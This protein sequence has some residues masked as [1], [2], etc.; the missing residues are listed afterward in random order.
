[1][2]AEPAQSPQVPR[3]EPAQS[4]Q[5][6]SRPPATSHRAA[7]PVAAGVTTAQTRPSPHQ[8]ILNRPVCRMKLVPGRCGA[9]SCAHWPSCRAAPLPP[10]L[11]Q[12]Q[13]TVGGL[14][15]QGTRSPPR[16]DS[17]GHS[18]GPHQDTGIEARAAGG[19]QEGHRL[20]RDRCTPEWAP[21]GVSHSVTGSGHGAWLQGAA[22]R[23]WPV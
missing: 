18:Q 21:V 4:P 9:P 17:T 16:P 12:P 19:S 7:V 8:L 1:M 14:G 20:A 15:C 5:V 22:G 3:A 2:C 6:P 13:H 10:C 23:G 11:P